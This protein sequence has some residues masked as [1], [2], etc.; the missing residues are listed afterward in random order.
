M[1]CRLCGA[2]SLSEQMLANTNWALGTYLSEIVI[3]AI[4]IQEKA[5]EISIKR[6]PFYPGLNVLIIIM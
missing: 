2:K 6:N 4:F 3:K 1:A 5:L